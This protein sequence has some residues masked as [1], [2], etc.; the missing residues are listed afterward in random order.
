[1]GVAQRRCPEAFLIRLR[2]WSDT[3]VGTRERSRP[4]NSCCSRTTGISIA[5]AASAGSLA[6]PSQAPSS[7][8]VRPGSRGP[9]QG[10]A[11]LCH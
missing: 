4:C 2:V 1:M 11:R 6:W 3:Q 7:C 8:P 9:A 5:R 10:V